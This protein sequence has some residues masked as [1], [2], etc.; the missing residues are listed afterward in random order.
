VARWGGEVTAPRSGG[1]VVA[2]LARV[3][4][5]RRGGRGG[6]GVEARSWRRGW[7]RGGVKARGFFREVERC[8]A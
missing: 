3:W 2:A 7:R 8:G 4:I 5:E 6:T 1:A